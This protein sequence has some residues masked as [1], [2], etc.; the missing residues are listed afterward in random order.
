MSETTKAEPYE[1]DAQ[2]LADAI[3]ADTRA[4]QGDDVVIDGF[5]TAALY[6]RADGTVGIS[7]RSTS[8][9]ASLT[10]EIFVTAA[11]LVS[12]QVAEVEEPMVSTQ[13]YT[14]TEPTF[15]PALRRE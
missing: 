7:V 1:V 9:S 6:R 15:E 13:T 10:A 5:V 12:D 2:G 11:N 14:S 3:A 4:E 8:Q